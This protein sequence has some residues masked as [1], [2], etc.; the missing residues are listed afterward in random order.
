VIFRK[1]G[2]ILLLAATTVS[3]ALAHPHVFIN[4]KMTVVFDG[5]TLKGVTFRWKFDEI[6][7]A[8]LLASFRPDADGNYGAKATASIKSFAFDNLKNYH[9]FLAFFIGKSALKNIRI[10]QFA[11]SVVD[12]KTI[13]YSFFVPLDLRVKPEEQSVS[14]TVYDDTYF[15]AFDLMHT[16][17]VTI[18]GGDGVSV[19]LAVEKMKVKSLWPGQYMPDQ[20]VI[21]YKASPDGA[22]APAL[23][24]G[25]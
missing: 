25:S 4:N 14:V 1:P 11:P 22:G 9:Y 23:K 7:S 24:E 20:L 6:F 16:D 2:L 8:T 17:D 5:G 12:G 3:P 19:A 10:E 21:R 18:T 15:V 13:V